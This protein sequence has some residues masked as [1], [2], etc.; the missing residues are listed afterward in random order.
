MTKLLLAVLTVLT[1]GVCGACG[2]SVTVSHSVVLSGSALEKG[3]SDEVSAQASAAPEAV[4]CP[5]AHWTAKV[6]SSQ[7][8]TVK[9]DGVSFTVVVKVTGLKGT[10]AKLAYAAPSDVRLEKAD[11]EKQVS[12]MLA[13]QLGTTPDGVSCDAALAGRVGSDERCDV[14]VNGVSVPVTA[15]VTSVSDGAYVH[16][17]VQQSGTATVQRAALEK[18]ISSELAAQV[19]RTPDSV[20]CPAQGLAGT[21]GRTQRCTLSADGQTYGVT[22]TVTAAQGADVKFDIKVDDQPTASS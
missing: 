6:G 17:D 14:S 2:A 13:G 12:T 5:D 15:T 7:P 18:E 22:L 4:T 11:L 21:V 9:I 19:G 10:H 8:C 20:T 1:L 16:L 3:V